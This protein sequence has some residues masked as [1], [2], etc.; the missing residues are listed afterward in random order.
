[1]YTQCPDCQFSRPIGT[2]EL[3]NTR[4]MISC[5]N[6]SSMYDAL[7]L[8]S[9]KNSDNGP[10][11]FDSD[12]Y[13]E[14]KKQSKL[15][16]AFW[17]VSLTLSILLFIYQFYTFEAYN[18]TQNATSRGWLEKTQPFFDRK[19]PIYKNLDEFSILHGSFERN[20]N[21][22]FI[23]RTALT[24]QSSFTQ[25]HPAIKLTLID[26]TGSEF[27]SRI[28]FAEDYT[29][30]KST[31]TMPPESTIEIALTIATPSHNIGGYHFEL[32]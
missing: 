17:S 30:N 10:V 23:F 4:G 6:C 1:M 5:D 25:N 19:L 7:E 11:H 15:S 27:A 14:T 16:P 8:L 26:F 32:I 21:S 31:S 24:N 18:L 3:R 12:N 22:T 29:P 13:A 28:F 20:A 2:E 9:D